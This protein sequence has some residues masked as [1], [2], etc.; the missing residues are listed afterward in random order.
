MSQCLNYNCCLTQHFQEDTE[1][2]HKMEGLL[3]HAS[4]SPLLTM[5]EKNAAVEASSM[6]SMQKEARE[7]HSFV[8][9]YMNPQ[10]PVH[11]VRDKIN[12]DVISEG[13]VYIFHTLAL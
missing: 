10:S 1:L 12:Q 5:N 11:L 9:D 3:E 8:L 6:Y 7:E 2:A 4:H 13:V